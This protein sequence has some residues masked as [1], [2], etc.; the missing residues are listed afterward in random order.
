MT[1]SQCV[2]VAFVI[3]HVKLMRRIIL[4]SAVCL[5]PPYF[6]TLFHKRHDFRGKKNVIEHKTCVLIFYNF[7]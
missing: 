6:P 1:Y 3:Q 7:V 2:C 4:S 5:T